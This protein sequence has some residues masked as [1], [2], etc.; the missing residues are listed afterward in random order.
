[1]EPSPIYSISEQNTANRLS[2]E[3]NLSELPK[4]LIAVQKGAE[5]VI[6]AVTSSLISHH[7]GLMGSC[8]LESEPWDYICKCVYRYN[9][10]FLAH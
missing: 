1:M 7:S 8:R 9:I 2:I 6:Q 5:R 3:W 4:K 10:D